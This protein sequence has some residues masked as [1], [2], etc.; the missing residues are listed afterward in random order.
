MPAFSGPRPMNTSFF[1]EFF[2]FSRK[3][4]IGILF[5]IGVIFL[6]YVIPDWMYEQEMTHW[7]E[8]K[9]TAVI[10]QRLDEAAA[11]PQEISIR[12]PSRQTSKRPDTLRAK[13]F[14]F[15]PNLLDQK[16]FEE[17]GLRPSLIR[18]IMNYRSRGGHF[19]NPEDIGKLYGITPAE[20]GVLLPYVRI[21]AIQGGKFERNDTDKRIPKSWKVDINAADSI[22]WDALPGIGPILSGRIIRYRE[23]LGGF[24]SVEQVKETYGIADSVFDRLRPFLHLGAT[25]HR[26]LRVNE[27]TADELAKHPYIG[28]ALS[29]EIIAYRQMH[30][31][32]QDTLELY[33][34]VSRPPSDLRRA[35]PYL[36]LE[37]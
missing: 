9:D 26:R 19:R 29:R 24:Y 7:R 23:R 5:L 33:R 14:P 32:F 4:R 16:G 37:K 15:D 10:V 30:G 31:A 13:L 34:L 36:E 18:N 3:E 1:Q 20:T 28:R 21:P 27:A 22:Q 2:H 12:D 8:G 35:L 25:P 17:L 11:V 6:L